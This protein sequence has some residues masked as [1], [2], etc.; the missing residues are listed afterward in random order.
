[1]TAAPG[2][3]AV[4]P[5]APTTVHGVRVVGMT[6]RNEKFIPVSEKSGA[7]RDEDVPIAGTC[8]LP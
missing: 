7:G 5:G 4:E 6:I 8:E 2:T 3:S 1:M